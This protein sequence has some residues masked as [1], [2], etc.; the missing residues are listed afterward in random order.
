MINTQIFL[1]A[2]VACTV[3]QIVMVAAGHFI[4]WVVQNIFTFGGMMI[5]ATAGYLYSQ[6]LDKG[7]SAGALGGAIAGGLC[8][9]IGFSIS[10]LLG[11][12]PVP[13]LAFI[14]GVSILTGAVGGPFGQMAANLRHLR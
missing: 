6:D 10:A 13:F 8:A 7:W 11:D 1:R 14:T 2:A 12:I 9:A 5:S 4:P 3:M